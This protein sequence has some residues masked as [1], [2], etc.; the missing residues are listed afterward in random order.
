MRYD[1]IE[2][3]WNVDLTT[4]S[5]AD[6]GRL[7]YERAKAIVEQALADPTLRA[8]AVDGTKFRRDY[9]IERIGS[10]PAVT[11]QNPRVRQLLADTDEALARQSGRADD[12]TR[13]RVPGQRSPEIAELKA[14]I[15]SLRRRLEIKTA[16]ASETFAMQEQ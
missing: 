15:D 14:T 10:G 2:N 6:R 7:F 13:P 9:L 11:S 3:I 16:E 4:L 1:D 5:N 12:Q 8:Q